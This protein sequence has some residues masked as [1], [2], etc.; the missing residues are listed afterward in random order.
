[1]CVFEKQIL[2]LFIL[3]SI[4]EI[5]NFFQLFSSLIISYNTI[6]MSFHHLFSLISNICIRYCVI[7]KCYWSGTFRREVLN[8][9][10][11][12]LLCFIAIVSKVDCS[13]VTWRRKFQTCGTFHFQES[14]DD[15][16]VELCGR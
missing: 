13:G 2:F 11:Y 12:I 14:S 5:N 3:Y 9:R 16:Y 6:A 7:D 8:A 1:M 15:S 4:Y 10:I